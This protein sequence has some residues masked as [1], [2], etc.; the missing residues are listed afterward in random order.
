MGARMA[1]I[2]A[3]GGWTAFFWV[4]WLSGDAGRYLGERTL[5]VVPFGAV[6]TAIAFVGLVLQ[7]R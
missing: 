2:V 4:I 3:V 7:P 5:W 1:R 6:A